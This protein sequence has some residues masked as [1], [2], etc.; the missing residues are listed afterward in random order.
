MLQ[1]LKKRLDEE[2]LQITSELEKIATKHPESGDWVAVP[3]SGDVGNAD[4]NVGADAAEEWSKRRAIM[5]QL[6]IRHRN[7]ARALEKI[8]NN[9]YGICEIS[10]KPI[11][12]ERLNANPAARTNIENIDR[13]KE[14]PI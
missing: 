8:S 5:S 13:E 14:L 7:V 11:E 6:E 2:L 12:E 3:A 4:A 1:E 9:I 10:G